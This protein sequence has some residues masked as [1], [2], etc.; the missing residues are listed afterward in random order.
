M[1]FFPS[2]LMTLAVMVGA[3]EPRVAN[4]SE[5]LPQW[6][7]QAIAESRQ[8]GAQKKWNE[9]VIS[10]RKIHQS[11]PESFEVAVEFSK[12]LVYLGRREESLSVLQ[13]LIA[14]SSGSIRAQATR[15]A[16]VMAR[17][18]MTQAVSQIYQDGLLLANQRKYKLAREKFGKAL[19]AEADN[20]EV[21][22]R[23]GQCLYLDGDVDSASERL[24][25]AK[26]L[27]PYEPQI[28]LWLGRVM[29]DRGEL[30]AGLQ[31]VKSAYEELPRSELATV[32]YAAGLAQS[33]KADE[34][35]RVL[36][37]DVKKNPM[38]LHSLVSS[39]RTLLSST[40]TS[41]S[42]KIWEIRKK[43]QVALSRMPEYVKSDPDGSEGEMGLDLRDPE[44]LRSEVDLMLETVEA[45][46]GRFSR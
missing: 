16:R 29:L 8:L 13:Q 19:D 35:V 22:L 36:E 41:E 32:W 26:K 39:A 9:A 37:S 3:V 33:G 17:L 4:S 1:R 10:L 12:A 44:R 46:L 7:A 15:R 20:A 11:H 14:K 40:P 42:Q 45:R 28:R 38:H 25:A 24:K 5:V 18:F 30:E 2:S 23:L 6:A 31:E 34:A 43:L 27:S 21:L